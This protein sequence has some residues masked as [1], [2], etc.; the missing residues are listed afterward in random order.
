[1][2]LFINGVEIE[3]T[4]STTLSRTLQVNDIVSL[5][6]RQANYTN[7][8]SLPKTANNVRA[9][10]KLG[11]VGVNS[12][13]PYQRNA[14]YLYADSGECLVYNGWSVVT[15]TDDSYKISIYDGNIDLYKAIE[16]RSLSELD[17]T[18]INHT[19][20]LTNVLNSWEE[21]SNYRYI[22]ADY[23]GKML[24]N[25][26]QINI[27]YLVPAVNVKYLWDKV[28]TT[29]D[30]TY[31][32]SVF[33]TFAFTN[34]WMTYPKGILSFVPDVEYFDSNS[35]SFPPKNIGGII[36]VD[37]VGRYFNFDTS[38]LS[39]GTTIYANKHIKPNTEGNYR[40]EITGDITVETSVFSRPVRMYYGLNKDG[41]LYA[42]DI[43]GGV[44]ID[45]F[46][47]RQ[48]HTVNENFIISLSELDSIC[49]FLHSTNNITGVTNTLNVTISKVESQDIDFEGAFIDFKTKD[50]LNEILT[51]F[52]LTPFK[53]K[54]TNH[55]KFLTLQELLQDN[56][57]VDWS[58]ENNK[59]VRKISERYVYGNYAQTNDFIYNYNDKGSDHNDGSILID[60]V[61][62]QDNNVVI[63]SK[64][65]SPEKI[66]TSDLFKNTNVYKLWDKQIKDNSEI[67]YKPLDK[68]FYMMR[69]ETFYFDNPVVIGS[70]AAGTAA[71]INSAPY[72]NF[73]KLDFNSIIQD[74]YLPINQILNKAVI[75]ENEIYLNEKDIV[76]ID[77]SK[78]YFI[79]ELNSYFI[80]NKVNNFQ[81]KGKV[82]CEMIKADYMPVVP[83][84]NQNLEIKN[85]G[86]IEVFNI[87]LYIGYIDSSNFNPGTVGYVLDGD[88]IVLI[89]AVDS[90]SFN[91]EIST[92]PIEHTIYVTDGF[93]TTNTV[94]F[95]V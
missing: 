65:Y 3:L 9:M 43:T 28:F 78:L 73:F 24:Y 79:R 59:F 12:G 25:T 76:D 39:E 37:S 1:M 95:I 53:D 42:E 47:S 90:F 72:E 66:K 77:F 19:K 51:R 31:E 94:T 18:E 29:Y 40:I 89:G 10:L 62:L 50:F 87:S 23:N 64:I 84:I 92:P 21:G 34:L 15:S 68:R 4:A 63:S 69:E 22:I 44:Q 38:T 52:S 91:V 16:N 5:S 86:K 35:I 57:V 82:K 67:E 85:V 41:I 80:L 75:M 70:E 48:T 74:Y 49:F 30:F 81:G 93:N 88:P 2:K 20:T 11:V 7:T 14:T 83:Q 8:Y 26:S 36:N 58:A 17:L 56:Q 13:V 54:Y 33:D 27:D 55:Y 71:I 45:A 60:N 61:N 32:G 46:L 6:N